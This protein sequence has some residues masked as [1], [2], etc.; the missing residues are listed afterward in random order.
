MLQ[1]ESGV[2][3]D[4][5]KKRIKRAVLDLR[6]AKIL[7]ATDDVG[8]YR[9]AYDSM[10][11]AGITLVLYHGYRPKPA[12]FHKTLTETVKAI[13]GENHSVITKKFEQMRKNRHQAIYDIESITK[14]EAVD[15]IKTADKF[16]KEISEYIKEADPQK[17]LF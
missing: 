2:G 9:L 15:A 8:A 3:A 5:I 1:K 11:Q 4:Q 12:N 14:T 6:N 16:I 7:S 17:E 13:L 10:L